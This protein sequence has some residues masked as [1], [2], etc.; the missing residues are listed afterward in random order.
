MSLLFVAFL[1]STK[2]ATDFRANVDTAQA[3][4]N[5][6]RL[7][8][9]HM[10]SILNVLACILWLDGQDRAFSFSLGDGGG[11]QWPLVLLAAS[12]PFLLRGGPSRRNMAPSQTLETGLPVCALLAILV[13]C[14]YGPVENILLSHCNSPLRTVLPM[15]IL[16]PPCL[17]AALAFILHTL[18]CRCAAVSAIL[19]VVALFIRQQISPTHHMQHRSDFFALSATVN[20]LVISTAFWIYRQKVVWTPPPEEEENIE[21]LQP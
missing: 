1:D 7:R 19:L 18:K 3:V 21:A 17:A 4:S 9:F 11:Q 16:C 2:V 5:L 6:K 13:L 12:S 10:G 20:S 8:L 14:W 15:L